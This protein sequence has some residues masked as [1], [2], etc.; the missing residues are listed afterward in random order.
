LKHEVKKEMTKWSL[1]EF[2]QHLANIAAQWDR[3]A[4]KI[5]VEFR[6]LHLSD[7]VF[8]PEMQKL[9]YPVQQ[10]ILTE[11]HRSNELLAEGVES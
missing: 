3:K 9:S 1:L 10:L 7:T 11:Q 2:V 5:R 4:E 8:W 6:S